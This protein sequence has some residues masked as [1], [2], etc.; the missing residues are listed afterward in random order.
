MKPN[1]V[2]PSSK[3]VMSDVS[4][5]SLPSS[6][7]TSYARRNLLFV[8]SRVRIGPSSEA[9]GSNKL[10]DNEPTERQE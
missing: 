7:K 1:D 3:S 5:G 4:I 9:I 8:Y 2:S 6:L 10:N